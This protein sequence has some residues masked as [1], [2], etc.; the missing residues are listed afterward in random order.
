ME[1]FKQQWQQAEQAPVKAQAIVEAQA[2]VAVTTVAMEGTTSNGSGERGD[3]RQWKPQQA[4]VPA[5]KYQQAAGWQWKGHSATVA[6]SGAA[7]AVQASKTTAM[8]VTMSRWQ[9]K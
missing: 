8:V 5:A 6:A 7:T 3:R 4:T 2:T 9:R 1:G